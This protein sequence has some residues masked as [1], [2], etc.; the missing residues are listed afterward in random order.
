MD[1]QSFRVALYAFRELGQKDPRPKNYKFLI[2]EQFKDL[3]HIQIGI[4]ILVR[5]SEFENILS[6]ERMILN[7]ID[8]TKFD[9]IID[10]NSNFH[11]GISRLI[12]MLKSDI[13]IGFSTP[14]SDQ[15]YNIQL[16]VSKS[17]IMERGYKQINMMLAP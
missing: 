2:R 4:P 7:Q 1:E 13:K 9:I 16:D 11:L 3:F 14:F 15:F 10:L 17:G 5:N 12:S 6:D 8:N